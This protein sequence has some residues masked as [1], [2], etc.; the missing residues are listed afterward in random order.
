MAANPGANDGE[1]KIPFGQQVLDSPFW[2]LLFG[3]VVMLGFYTIWGWIELLNLPQST[4][5]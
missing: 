3:I 1:E 5:P 4:L 2:L